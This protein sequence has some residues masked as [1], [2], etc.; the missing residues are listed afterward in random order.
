MSL[1][2]ARLR[3]RSRRSSTASVFPARADRNARSVSE[4]ALV[5]E[6]KA[7]SVSPRRLD[8]LDSPV[9]EESCLVGRRG[10]NPSSQQP[11]T[12]PSK[13]SRAPRPRRLVPRLHRNDGC[14][15]RAAAPRDAALV[16]QVGRGSAPSAVAEPPPRPLRGLG[17]IRRSSKAIADPRGCDWH[18]GGRGSSGRSVR[19]MLRSIFSARSRRSSSRSG[20]AMRSSVLILAVLRGP[21]RS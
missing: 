19:S 4:E 17:H 2:L 6:Q 16:S 5:R 7:L 20:C 21:R 10:P 13:L 14:F 1:G 15:A 18:R 8:S 11:D 12:F 9:P 3:A